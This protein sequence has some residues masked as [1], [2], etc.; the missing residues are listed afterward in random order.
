MILTCKRF[1]VAVITEER[2]HEVPKP[3]AVMLL[4]GQEPSVSAP[5]SPATPRPA[6]VS[7]D[8]EGLAQALLLLIGVQAG[9][10]GWA[11]CP[12]HEPQE[13]L[14]VAGPHKSLE[15]RGVP[16][17][18][19][20]QDEVCTAESPMEILLHS[21]TRPLECKLPIPS[22]YV[23]LIFPSLPECMDLIYGFS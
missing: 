22:P 6:P 15:C 5:R 23:C 20:D 4:A 9:P 8:N 19:S 14:T 12:L 10:R 18:R 3:T 11:F 2:P 7:S 17:D 21:V 13:C 1:S 16:S